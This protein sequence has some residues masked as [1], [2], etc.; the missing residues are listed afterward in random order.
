MLLS[1]LA[2]RGALG[3][4]V[5]VNLSHGG[6][7]DIGRKRGIILRLRRRYFAMYAGRGFGLYLRLRL[8]NRGSG[9]PCCENPLLSS[10]MQFTSRKLIRNELQDLVIIGDGAAAEIFSLPGQ[11]PEGC[12]R[13]EISLKMSQEE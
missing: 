3:R 13:H 2:K 8:L 4:R 9:T 7:V 6:E 11:M 12:H 5:L 1:Q 10:R